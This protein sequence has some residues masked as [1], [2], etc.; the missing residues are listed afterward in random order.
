MFQPLLQSRRFDA[1][2][3]IWYRYDTVDVPHNGRY[4]ARL[5]T[6]PLLE[7]CVGLLAQ[8]YL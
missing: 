6:F 8:L 3:N 5:E 4:L 7:V 2:L 1:C